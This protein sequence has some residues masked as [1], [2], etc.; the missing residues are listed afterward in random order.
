MANIKYLTLEGLKHFKSKIDTNFGAH[1]TG[2]RTA[3]GVNIVL[4][5]NV[6]TGETFVVVDS[7]AIP[8]VDANYAGV[9]T[10]VQLTRL[11]ASATAA[12]SSIIVGT[13]TIAADSKAD[14]LIVAAG[15]GINISGDATNDKIT[16]SHADTSTATT[17]SIGPSQAQTQTAETD[18]SFTVPQITLDGFGHVTALTGRTITVKDTNTKTTE[19]GHYDPTGTNG[20][21]SKTGGSK[22]TSFDKTITFVQ[23]VVV[24]SN[25]HLMSAAF[26]SLTLTETQLSKGTTVGSGNAISDIDV[27][28]HQITL[29]KTTLA[30]PGDVADALASAKEYADSLELR[31]FDFKG[32]LPS[33]ATAAGPATHSIGDVYRI[34]T[35]GTYLGAT[36][37]A[38]DFILCTVSGTTATTSHWASLNTNWSVSNKSATL[39]PKSTQTLAQ[40]GGVD[41]KVYVPD[42]EL[43]GHN[44]DSVY[45][46]LEHTH[47]LN[48]GVDD[49]G[50]VN[51]SISSENT[52]L[53]QTATGFTITA[54]HKEY[55][56]KTIVPTG[57]LSWGQTIK[58][59][60]VVSDAYGHVNGGELVSFTM[61]SNPNTDTKVT[62]VTNH[63]KTDGYA[64]AASGLY[65]I[66]T[67]AA[68]H[69]TAQ[70]AVVKADI[71]A[72]GIPAQDTTYTATDGLTITNKT[73]KTVRKAEQTVTGDITSAV[74]TG[75]S[76]YLTK[77][78]ILLDSNAMYTE[79]QNIT[80]ADIDALF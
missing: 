15:S 43:K 75:K 34:A 69:V 21:I 72:L 51:L 45:S 6:P 18:L 2:D 4:R 29:T 78:P 23:S 1:L 12:F 26:G 56:A 7:V 31:K 32:D 65:K 60:S 58:I 64:A 3:E 71:T 77:A 57:S 36:Y 53:G 61:P 63:Y 73:I 19:A 40:V 33:T 46:K 70:T 27:N 55:T 37:E 66:S 10:P 9:M 35:A 16:I 28:N 41:I 14:S 62:S 11:N 8:A 67:D 13:T 30:T 42:F 76:N 48:H 17:S 38:G 54:S 5:N 39:S 80:N 59:P 68:G 24:D 79:I 22:V 44:H 74:S 49:D 25:K 47:T 50:I 20:E 52:K